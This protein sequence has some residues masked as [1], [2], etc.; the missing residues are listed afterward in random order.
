M[1]CRLSKDADVWRASCLKSS[2]RMRPCGDPSCAAYVCVVPIRY[3]FG[4]IEQ[5][6]A[7]SL[8]STA[9]PIYLYVSHYSY[10]GEV[11]GGAVKI[12]AEF[13]RRVSHESGALSSGACH[14][15]MTGHL[16]PQAVRR[17]H[18]PTT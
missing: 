8:L 17:E 6:L 4:K 9:K 10:V 16:F 15:M 7:T 13:K 18:M 3:D 11:R 2:F 12:L 1:P 14:L 5:E